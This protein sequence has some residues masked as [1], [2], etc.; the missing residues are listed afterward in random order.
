MG[1][2]IIAV[3]IGML[4]YSNSFSQIT[5][6]GQGGKSVAWLALGVNQD[7]NN[8]WTSITQAAYS[9]HSA[10]DTWNGLK[11]S[12][13]FT[14]RQ[15]IK[16]KFAKNWSFTNMFLFAQRYYNDEAHPKLI[17]EVRYAPSVNYKLKLGR[18]SIDQKV[19]T[20]FRKYYNPGF[21]KALPKPFDFRL[22]YLIK[23]TVGLD[24]AKRNEII[25][26]TEV[27]AS[28]SK[29]ET[30]KEVEWSEF[31][32]NETRVSLYFRHKC[33]EKKNIIF[34]AGA[35]SQT[36]HTKR[37]EKYRETVMLQFDLIIVNPFS[38]KAV[39]RF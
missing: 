2:L 18:F 16:Y 38:K 26:L 32:F 22:R 28:T 6:Q 23:G 14:V 27:F 10:L 24:K 8:K 5:A 35:M 4:A 25:A 1:R 39:P 20:E 13:V 11:Q 15:G 30:Q 9:R 34:D 33:G 29:Y 19:T 12:G 37:Q 7:L 36:W 21:S 3:A 17:N 31:T